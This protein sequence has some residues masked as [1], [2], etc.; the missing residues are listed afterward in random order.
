MKT[1]ISLGSKLKDDSKPVKAD[2]IV[3]LSFVEP[4]ADSAR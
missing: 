4:N 3:S 2:V 1:S